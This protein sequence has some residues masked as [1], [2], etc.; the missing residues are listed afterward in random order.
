MIIQRR[1]GELLF[2]TQ[3]AH[4]AL[5]AAIM[6][7]W[8]LGGL[9]DHP[10]REAILIATRHHDDGW[11]EEDARLHI[12]PDGEPL[13][14]IAVPP[15]VKQRIWPRATERVLR[16]SPYAAAL[17]AEHALTIHEPLGGDPA[18]RAFFARM[19]VI[20]SSRAGAIAAP[21]PLGARRRLPFR[22]RRRSALSHPL[23]R[24]DDGDGGAL[25]PRYTEG[26]HA[27][28]HARSL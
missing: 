10:R 18:W 21:R 3:A 15:D 25:L 5:A 28:D 20:R 9:P 14:F 4:A 23:Q 2:I 17:V 13:D 6:A 12:G 26:H 24:L 11:R 19:Q 1:G 27:R 8:A 7:E 16:R 22:A